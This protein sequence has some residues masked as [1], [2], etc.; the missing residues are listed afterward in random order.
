MTH[1]DSGE[2]DSF[3][4]LPATTTTT[5]RDDSDDDVED[6]KVVDGINR[7][8]DKGISFSVERRPR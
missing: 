2:F 8:G 6:F 5:T 3:R 7:F 4:F 1:V